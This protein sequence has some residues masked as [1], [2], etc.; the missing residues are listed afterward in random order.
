MSLT[1]QGSFVEG[2]RGLPSELLRVGGLGLVRV[3]Y[4]YRGVSL[5]LVGGRPSTNTI[6]IQINV[7][8]MPLG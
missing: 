8:I 2:Q 3:S 5:V 4:P 1:S 6:L 7:A